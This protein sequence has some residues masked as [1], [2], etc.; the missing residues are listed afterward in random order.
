MKN[1]LIAM[2]MGIITENQVIDVLKESLKRNPEYRDDFFSS[3]IGKAKLYEDGYPEYLYFSPGVIANFS[4]DTAK[5]ILALIKP[6]EVKEWMRSFTRHINAL[7]GYEAPSYH[8]RSSKKGASKMAQWRERLRKVIPLI[9]RLVEL[10]LLDPRYFSRKTRP[11][12][13]DK[14]FFDWYGYLPEEE[15]ISMVK[16]RPEQNRFSFFIRNHIVES[17]K[18]RRLCSF[19]HFIKSVGIP[20]NLAAECEKIIAE[21]SF[22]REGIKEDYLKVI[23][24]HTL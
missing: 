24:A 18:E 21:R 17:C 7:P 6:E 8:N 12:D 23:R 16:N 11:E 14:Y 13:N 19:F 15:V 2:E 4:L 3:L 10:E 20:K 22:S 5:K 1:L 9:E